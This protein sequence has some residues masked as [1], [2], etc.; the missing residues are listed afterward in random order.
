MDDRLRLSRRIRFLLLAWLRRSRSGRIEFI[1]NDRLETADRADTE[2]DEHN[3][4][5]EWAL[6]YF[7]W[8]C[9]SI[10]DEHHFLLR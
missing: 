2:F 7:G 6:P 1:V 10:F 3:F 4:Q 5:G 8:A 9:P